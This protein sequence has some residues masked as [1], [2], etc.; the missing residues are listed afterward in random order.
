VI[1]H[2]AATLVGI[3]GLATAWLVWSGRWRSLG[4]SVIAAN[5]AWTSLPFM[6]M[7]LL[8][9]GLQP[10]V[11]NVLY[12]ITF[13]IAI[14]CV[15]LLLWEPKWFG[16]RWWRELD[17]EG[18]PMSLDAP[19]NAYLYAAMG[20][21]LGSDGSIPQAERMMAGATL[22]ARVRGTLVTDRF[23]RPSALQ[24]PGVVEG[25]F[26]L[27][28]RG[29]VFAA[30]RMEDKMRRRPVVERLAG[31]RIRHV[32]RLPR[33]TREGGGRSF[34]NLG[35]LVSTTLRIVAEGDS[36]IVETVH[37]RRLL[38]EMERLYGV[39]SIDGEPVSAAAHR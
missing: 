38:A 34:R 35:T 2:V 33:G 7:V 21:D 17:R 20:A 30:T 37:G 19:D 5:W 10:L 31:D 11:G 12:A 18:E 14:A 23:G 6:A 4:L 32:E 3:G 13:P 8:S 1:G 25:E 9:Y 26:R 16:P 27:Y 36:W 22:E 39:R 15:V 29:I 28:Q 24:K